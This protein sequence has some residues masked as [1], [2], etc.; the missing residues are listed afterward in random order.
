VEGQRK[1]ENDPPRGGKVCWGVFA[2]H[3]N[4]G[5]AIPSSPRGKG[6]CALGGGKALLSE[7]EIKEF[8]H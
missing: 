1:G 4:R 5:G 8:L 6:P 7:R 2:E 3:A